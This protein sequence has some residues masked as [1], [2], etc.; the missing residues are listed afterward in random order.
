M[1]I[2]QLQTFSS[3]V[4]HR[5]FTKAAETLHLSQPAVTRQIAALESAVGAKLLDRRIRQVTPTAAGMALQSYATR[6]LGLARDCRLTVEAVERGVIGHLRVAA[7]GTVATYV[8]PEIL[9]KFRARHPAIDISVHTC[10]SDA[11]ARMVADDRADAAVVMDFRGHA[12][13]RQTRAG[14][15]TLVA[16]MSP[17]HR[18]ADRRSLTIADLADEPLIV[19]LPG[20]NLRRLVDGIFHASGAVP[21]VTVEVDHLEAMKKM[22]AAQLGLAIVPDLVVHGDRDGL[23][24]ASIRG[25]RQP[26][27]CWSVVYRKDR[28]ESAALRFFLQCLP[29]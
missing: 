16:A 24:I 8:L 5:S 27:R 1:D 4:E 2:E 10:G 19:M 17:G 26:Q 9:A 14:R 23:R 25:T 15:Y 7:S 11:A 29:A 13:L 6:I 12:D 18:L 28:S 3:V 21:N 20:T 22:A